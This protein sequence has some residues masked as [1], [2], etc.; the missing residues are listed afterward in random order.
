MTN[1]APDRV[2]PATRIR[3]SAMMF[4]QMFVMGG[5]IVTMATYLAQE[6]DASAKQISLAAL[7]Q[8]IGA[9]ITP[10]VVG[11]LADRVVSAQKLMGAL[12]IVAGVLL[13]IASRVDS[14]GLFFILIMAYM[15]CFAGTPSLSSSVALH[16]LPDSAKQFPAIRV[17]GTVG[18]IVAGLLVGILGWEQDHRLV[19]TLLLSGGVGIALGLYCFTLPD[20]PPQGSG[21]SGWRAI[22][23]P[24]SLVLFRNRAFLFFFCAAVAI[25]IPLAFYYNFTNLYLN[26][27]G[28]RSAAALQTI[29]QASEVAI[30]LVLGALISRLGFKKTL[31]LGLA[32]WVVRYLCFAIAVDGPQLWLI[33]IGLTLHGLC[34]GFFMVAGQLYVDR[35]AG[36][37]H[38]STALGLFALATAG[39]GPLVGALITGPVVDALIIPGGHDWFVIWLIPAAMSLVVLLLIVAFFHDATARRSTHSDGPV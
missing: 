29:G 14:F 31:L 24:D 3:L 1:I 33:V 13:L 30:L 6:L 20:T 9:M 28:L 26:E 22:F 4:L 10:F 11:A 12:H 39:V 23:G 7:S 32:A 21:R 2:H 36:P 27:I 18:W 17:F 16:Q 38:R 8:A 15:L 5:W 19:L 34:F 37:A 35:I 25:C